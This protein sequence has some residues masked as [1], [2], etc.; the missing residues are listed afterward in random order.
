[1]KNESLVLIQNVIHFLALKLVKNDQ[2]LII[3]IGNVLASSS[4]RTRLLAQVYVVAAIEFVAPILVALSNAILIM[5]LYFDATQ[6]CGYQCQN[7]LEHLPKRDL[8]EF[9]EKKQLVT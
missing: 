9:T 5:V 4:N 3:K 2:D 8:L 1:M 7:Y 6:N